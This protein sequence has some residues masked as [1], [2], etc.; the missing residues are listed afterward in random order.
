MLTNG[1]L[2]FFWSWKYVLSWFVSPLG[3]DRNLKA[4]SAHQESISCSK[5]KHL[6]LMEIQSF[7]P[8]IYSR[9]NTCLMRGIIF[10]S[11]RTRVMSQRCER[12][13]EFLR[14]T[15]NWFMRVL[16]S[17]QV[18]SLWLLTQYHITIF[19]IKMLMILF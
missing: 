5:M 8:V 9:W 4:D 12:K 15:D 7:P 3:I 6:H 11:L 13:I 19:G 10:Y 1:F 14:C 18:P 2:L 16:L 17:L